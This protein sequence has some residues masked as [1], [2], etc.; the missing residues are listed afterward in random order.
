MNKQKILMNTGIFIFILI[1][2]NI[3][4]SIFG[5]DNTLIGVTSITATFILLERDLTASI[6]KNFLFFLL[7]N[8]MQ[9]VFA[10]VATQSLGVGII[11]NF[12]AMF[13]IGY[14]L[15]YNLRKPV[16]LP[17]GLQYVLILYKPIS[18]EQLPLRLMA[19][20]TGALV[21][22][23]FQI[24][25]NRNK[26]KKSSEEAIISIFKS[27]EMKVEKIR[28]GE[29][30]E[31]CNRNTEKLID[32]L[33][34]V[35]YDSRE[36]E[37]HVTNEGSIVL[38]I[39]FSLERINILL[40]RENAIDKQKYFNDLVEFLHMATDYLEK[41]V[42]LKKIEFEGNREYEEYYVAFYVLQE[43]IEKLQD[44]KIDRKKII[45]DTSLESK[46][47]N[48]NNLYKKSVVFRY[49]IRIGI[50]VSTSAAI[51]HYLNWPEGRW[52]VFTLFSLTQPYQENSV[53]RAKKRVFGTIIGAVIFV[54]LFTTFKEVNSRMIIILIVGYVSSY[55]VDYKYTMITTTISALGVAAMTSSVVGLTFERII[56]VLLGVVI[57]LIANKYLYPYNAEDGKCE[58]I[59]IYEDTANYI[60]IAVNDY[61]IGKA[62]SQIINNLFLVSALIEERL[63]LISDLID[64]NSESDYIKGMKKSINFS[65]GEYIII[66]KKQLL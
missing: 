53:I 15:T 44:M 16:Y 27:I 60:A 9:G 46:L 11:V 61:K 34:T 51:V 50:L 58:L 43:Y 62:N 45:G 20:A 48:K 65:Y 6:G 59:K 63:T 56:F 36:D 32:K 30:L 3:F 52:I 13:I 31:E 2:V 39:V 49:A 26:L 37:T 21:I 19:L 1:F 10:Y 41:K 40:D 7:L 33:K 4:K 38:N 66:N 42:P 64:V 12:F 23:T 28:K 47:K 14:T 18:I 54:I 55:F 5:D 57:S 25:L 29:S 24:L 17:F 22:I 8:L 35:V